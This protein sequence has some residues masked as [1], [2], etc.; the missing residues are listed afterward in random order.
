MAED[1]KD[2]TLIIK[3]DGLNNKQAGQIIN[4]VI[5]LKSNY[6]PEARGTIVKGETGKI[7]NSHQKKLGGNDNGKKKK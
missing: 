7:G 2:K 4:G 1:K 3:I 5:E 6:A